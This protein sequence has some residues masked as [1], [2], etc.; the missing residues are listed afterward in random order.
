[1]SFLSYFG[2]CNYH[3]TSKLATGLAADE[4]P[5]GVVLGGILGQV[6][7]TTAAVLEGKRPTSQISEKI[8]IQ[9]HIF[10]SFPYATAMFCI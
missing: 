5:L 10:P 4:N 7:C 8:A 3:L 2:G 9:I 1:M 6:L